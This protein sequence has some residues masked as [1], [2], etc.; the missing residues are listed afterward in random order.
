LLVALS[1]DERKRRFF[2]LTG[3]NTKMTLELLMEEDVAKILR[4]KVGTLQQW[5][6]RKRGPDYILVG[7]LPRYTPES[8]ESFLQKR[9][10]SCS[11]RG[12]VTPK[13][14]RSG[15]KRIHASKAK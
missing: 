7:D 8:I 10:V 3:E 9:I 13:R 6:S 11:P 12:R 1:R 15:Q 14:L 5:R 4:V 2:L